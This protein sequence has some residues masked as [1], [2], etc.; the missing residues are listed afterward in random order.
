MNTYSR[1]LLALTTALACCLAVPAVALAGKTT[2]KHHQSS[3]PPSAVQVYVEDVP[4]ASGGH[5]LG[6][7]GSGQGSSIPLSNYASSALARNGGSD[8]NVLKS[9]ATNSGL[10]AP[11]ALKGEASGPIRSASPS[12]VGSALDAG[13]GTTV[14]FAVLLA[15]AALIV[16]V[17]VA[18][19]RRHR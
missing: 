19:R 12:A 18:Q 13:W 1:P 11:K 10:G 17:A 5:P 8:T 6:S 16:G 9:I 3:S 2:K 15:S 14:L 4:T 7:S